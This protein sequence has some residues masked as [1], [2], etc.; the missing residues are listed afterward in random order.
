MPVTAIRP[1]PLQNPLSQ[2]LADLRVNVCPKHIHV[3]R[4]SDDGDAVA[5][6]LDFGVLGL[7]HI[8]RAFLVIHDLAEHIGDSTVYLFLQRIVREHAVAADERPYGSAVAQDVVIVAVLV[9]LRED[10]V[11]EGPVLP[12]LVHQIV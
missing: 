2:R 10:I 5:A 11:D 3:F 4:Q 7:Q 6:Q 1:L 9:K 8:P 12:D